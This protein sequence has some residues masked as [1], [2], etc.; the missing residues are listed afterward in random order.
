V[1]LARTEAVNPQVI[2]YLNR[3]S[4]LLFV[5]ARALNQREEGDILWQPGKS[6]EEKIEQKETKETKKEESGE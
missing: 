6:V 4:D 2:V 5:L 1:T 3:L